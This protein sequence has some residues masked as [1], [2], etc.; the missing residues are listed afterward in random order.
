VRPHWAVL[1]FIDL[2]EQGAPRT[3]VLEF[4]R[5]LAKHADVTVVNP[6]ASEHVGA[7]DLD[8]TRITSPRI[9]NPVR[10]WNIPFSAL[11]AAAL[12]R[13][14][15]RRRPLDVIYIRDD[16]R[17]VPA[18]LWAKLASV[19]SVFEVN[20]AIR[21]EV[22]LCTPNRKGWRTWPWRSRLAVQMTLLGGAYR[23]ADRVVA[24]TDALRR[25]LVGRHRVRPHRVG[26]FGNG[27]N[28]DLF[29]PLD[30][31]KSRRELGLDPHKR[32]VGF[33]GNMYG[34]HGL[35]DLVTAF[36]AVAPKQDDVRLLLVGDGVEIPRLKRL[37]RQTGV[38]SRID[39]V[40]RV[41]YRDVPRYINASDFCVGPF[42]AWVR[43]QIC[44]ASPLK[45]F[46]YLACGR[47]VLVSDLED[48]KFISE[49]GVGRLY[50]V[51]SPESLVA[52]LRTM[53]SLPPGEVEA[54]G[55]R[56]RRLAVERFS[57]DA[58]TQ[59]I[60]RFVAAVRP[61]RRPAGNGR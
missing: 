34:W 5:S 25:H 44:G 41:P 14:L 15:H 29:T 32:Y 9:G 38:E 22:V 17:A 12:L 20:G 3:H 21:E 35:G 61:A 39:F 60:V 11:S 56:A 36:A 10:F 58:T 48:M 57:W 43:N 52:G 33:V 6:T 51:G 53:L 59:G 7:V 30:T 28:T 16:V 4:S 23:G 49:S 26:V 40:G 31:L 46:E 55:T 18:L 54:M 8:Y 50:E 45:I 42:N 13:R 24:V 27:A 2:A 1:S 37:A 19:V 47:P